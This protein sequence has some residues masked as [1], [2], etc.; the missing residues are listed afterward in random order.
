MS[1]MLYLVIYIASYSYNVYC[2]GLCYDFNSIA[3]VFVCPR[4]Y[5][6]ILLYV[7]CNITLVWKNGYAFELL[8]DL[9]L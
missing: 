1:C 5:V 7:V 9:N 2:N 8:N 3:F 4:L 6:L